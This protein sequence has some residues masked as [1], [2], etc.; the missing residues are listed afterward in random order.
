[1]DSIL[2]NATSEQLGIAVR[3]NLHALFRSMA[4]LPESQLEEPEYLSRHLTFPKLRC[5]G[6]CVSTSYVQ[7]LCFFSFHFKAGNA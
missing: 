3:E 4:T 7:K 1:M 6:V 2:K 5:R